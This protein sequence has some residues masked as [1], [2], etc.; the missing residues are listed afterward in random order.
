MDTN[1]RL[2]SA[3]VRAVFIC[4]LALG[5]GVSCDRAAAGGEPGKAQS[6]GA[7]HM[8]KGEAAEQ[9]GR[10]ADALAAYQKAATLINKEKDPKAWTVPANKVAL[11]HWH[12]ASCEKAEELHTEVLGLREKRFG[13]EAAE[14]AESLNNLAQLLKDTNRLT[15]AE[16]LMRRAL[17][18]GEASFGK[19]HPKVAIRLNN[20]ARLLQDTNR[21]AEAEP[22]MR[23]ALAMD[24]ASFGKDHSDVAID[25]NNLATLHKETDRL[26]EAE[27]MM[28]GALR[29]MEDSLGREHPNS[30]TV[31]KNLAILQKEIE[32]GK[33]P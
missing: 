5:G 18:M 8:A 26:A 24:E 9:K 20:L 14:T 21:L 7:S 33:E 1:R 19:D 12:M 27:P 17:A 32:K 6:A 28:K 3:A 4:L 22:L 30:V 29:I 23:R 16:P 2:L 25:L 15:E 10:Y 13:P 31:M 11:M